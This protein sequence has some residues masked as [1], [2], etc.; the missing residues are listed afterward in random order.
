[1][2]ARGELHVEVEDGEIIVTLPYSKYGVTYYKPARPSRCT[3]RRQPHELAAV[4][5]AA[6]DVSQWVGRP[7]YRVAEMRRP[8]LKEYA[9][10]LA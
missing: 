7:S 1:M 4:C 5:H 6:G 3:G 10:A 2:S 8:S 9:L